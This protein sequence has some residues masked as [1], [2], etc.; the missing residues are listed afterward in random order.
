MANLNQFSV[1]GSTYSIQEAIQGQTPL[2]FY[3]SLK[4]AAYLPSIRT[5]RSGGNAQVIMPYDEQSPEALFSQM[6]AA[7]GSE[8]RTVPAREFYWLE[9]DSYDT[10]TFVVNQAGTSTVS[11]NATINNLSK[12]NQGN[13]TK[14]LAGYYA[15]VKELNRQWVQITAVNKA[16]GVV[17]FA[18]INGETLDMSKYGRYTIIID[19]LRRYQLGDQNDIPVEGMVANPPTMYKAFAQKFEKGFAINQDEIDN[20]VYDRD[21]K[22][23][24]GLDTTGKPIDYYYIPTIHNQ[25]EGLIRDNKNLNTLF[26]QRDYTNKIGFDGIIPTAEKYG[27]FNAG[28]DI[29]SNVSLKQILFGM[30]KTLRRVNGCKDYMLAH[31]F[32]F[33]MDWSESISDI[34]KAAGQ[35]VRYEMFGPGGTGARN[36]DYFSFNGF[37]AFG[38]TFT[39]YM[40]DAFDSRRYAN[41]LEYFAL[42]MPLA[43]FKDQNGQTVPFITY[44][45]LAGAEP[46]KVDSM[47]T[48]DARLRGGRTLRVFCQ[49]TYG[50]EIHAPTRLGI[51]RK[52]VVS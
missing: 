33:W 28:Y 24:K 17:T 46:A 20:Y 31:D 34:I 15:M 47:W 8:T 2:A 29:F 5:V 26:G 41:I 1:D 13:Y 18:P 25:L 48:D 14:P 12:S 10:M 45:H 40:I 23:I 42:M 22:V 35:S 7:F 50:Q 38:Y 43:K 9:Y 4:Q 21:F 3:D 27:M 44:C 32:G 19:P 30:I 39:P 11:V 52:T 51:I 16:T 49:T 36:F 37:K 6:Q